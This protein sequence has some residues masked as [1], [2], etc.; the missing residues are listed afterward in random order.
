MQGVAGHDDAVDLLAHPTNVQHD[1][2]E[3]NSD[4]GGCVGVQVYRSYFTCG[5]RAM[6]VSALD[7]QGDDGQ[8][9]SGTLEIDLC[10]VLAFWPRRNLLPAFV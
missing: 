8:P 3:F 10:R 6:V 2:L 1:P 4:D 5:Q 9:L 7:E